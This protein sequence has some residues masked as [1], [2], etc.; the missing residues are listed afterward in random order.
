MVF[1]NFTVLIYLSFLIHLA[2]NWSI[3]YALVDLPPW[4]EATAAGVGGCT[5]AALGAP[6]PPTLTG[7]AGLA[8]LAL[9]SL[10]ASSSP[11]ACDPL[12]VN[13]GLALCLSKIAY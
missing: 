10:E 7:A 4:E 6:E 1:L 2:I 9:N 8:R 12:L 11:M 5:L 13:V 3:F